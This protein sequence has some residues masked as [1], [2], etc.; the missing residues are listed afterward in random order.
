MAFWWKA[1]RD[2][3]VPVWVIKHTPASVF[4]RD[5]QGKVIRRKRRDVFVSFFLNW[6]TARQWLLVNANRE[7]RESFERSE[8]LEHRIRK[9]Q[10]LKVEDWV[11]TPASSTAERFEEG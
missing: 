8:K 1:C 2:H 4:Y 10:G 9:L 6:E 3:I 5:D 11:G 7:L